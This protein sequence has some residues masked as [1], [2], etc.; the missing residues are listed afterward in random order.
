MNMTPQG[1]PSLTKVL[2]VSKHYDHRDYSD[3]LSIS[4]AVITL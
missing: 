1:A 2:I 4:E 3:A